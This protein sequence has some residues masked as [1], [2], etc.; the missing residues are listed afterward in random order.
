MIT[1]DGTNQLYRLISTNILKAQVVV[2]GATID[3]PIDR[4]ELSGNNIKIFAYVDETIIGNITK[5]R[6][7]SVDGKT[8]LERSDNLAKDN[9]GL[10]ILFEIQMQEV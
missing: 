9:R 3:V 2:S 4:T 8:F 7:I 6:L 10:L 1:T 5:Y